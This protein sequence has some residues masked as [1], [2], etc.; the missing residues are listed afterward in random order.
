MRILKTTLYLVVVLHIS[1]ELDHFQAEG[2]ELILLKY[3]DLTSLMQTV[4]GIEFN[5]N[6]TMHGLDAGKQIKEHH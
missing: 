6:S 4:F 1:L 5:L 2:D 3:V